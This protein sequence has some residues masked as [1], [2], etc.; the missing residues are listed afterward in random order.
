MM[1]PCESGRWIVIELCE[2]IGLT[3]FEVAN[4]EFFSSTFKVEFSALL[5]A[6]LL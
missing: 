1:S 3:G 6:D 5:V 2:E 4:F